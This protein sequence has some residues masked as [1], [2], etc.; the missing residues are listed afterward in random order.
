MTRETKPLRYKDD[1]I[2]IHTIK[3]SK[4]IITA[5]RENGDKY[6]KFNPTGKRGWGRGGIFPR[7]HPRTR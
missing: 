2:K 6:G 3:L 4:F 7:S 1:D 5:G